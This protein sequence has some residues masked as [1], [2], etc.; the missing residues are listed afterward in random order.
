[1]AFLDMDNDEKTGYRVG[2]VGAEAVVGIEGSNSSLLSSWVRIYNSSAGDDWNDI[3]LSQ[4]IIAAVRQNRAETQAPLDFLDVTHED[5]KRARVLFMTRDMSLHSDISDMAISAEGPAVV[6]RQRSVP[7]PGNILFPGENTLVMKIDLF[8]EGEATITGLVFDFAQGS[9]SDIDGMISISIFSDSNMDHLVGGPLPLVA[10]R[11]VPIS[12]VAVAEHAALQV[13][14]NISEEALNGEVFGLNLVSLTGSGVSLVRRESTPRAYIGT[15]GDFMRADGLFDDW[16][17]VPMHLDDSPAIP[18]IDLI[19]YSSNVD[20]NQSLIGFYT[21]VSGIFFQGS[22]IPLVPGFASPPADEGLAIVGR[23]V[24][25]LGDT[26]FEITWRTN[27]DS[28]NNFVT[29][30]THIFHSNRGAGREHHAIVGGM[31]RNTTYTFTV[32]SDTLTSESIEITTLASNS[33]ISFTAHPSA[34]ALSPT[35]ARISWTTNRYSE[36]SIVEYRPSTVSAWS[37]AFADGGWTN[38]IILEDLEPGRTYEYKAIVRNWDGTDLES[39][40][41]FFTTPE[42]SSAEKPYIPYLASD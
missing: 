10:G 3:L 14:V 28:A 37:R 18:S 22:E 42:Q 39:S 31:T 15:R 33:D 1:M 19:E 24:V 17:D 35:S 5:A 4:K 7:T 9:K 16:E 11:T 36:R 6:A 2:G 23:P 8:S 21:R 13:S 32:T 34:I 20:V 38:S 12:G 27:R 30:G 25:F 41:R 29:V 26:T 40:T